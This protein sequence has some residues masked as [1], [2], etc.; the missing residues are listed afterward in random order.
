[1][2]TNEFRK[3]VRRIYHALALF[4]GLILL[5]A[6]GL[7]YKLLNPSFLTFKDPNEYVLHEDIDFDRIVDGVHVSTGFKEG[8]GLQAVIV[9]C[10][11]CH[12]A[13]L[14]TQNRATKE[15]WVSIIRWMQ[16]TQNLWD[17]GQ[18]EELIVNYLAT[19]YA[20]EDKGRRESLSNIVWYELE[21]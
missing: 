18:N 11:P 7:I 13:K 16:K 9:S 14:V 1:M 3:S 15:G 4:F 12:S 10:T 20:P 6:S 5:L 21:N 2:N 8:E 19:Y 17:L